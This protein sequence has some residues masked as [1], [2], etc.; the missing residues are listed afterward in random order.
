MCREVK[1]A[2]KEIDEPGGLNRRQISRL[3][4]YAV[5]V[6][7]AVWVYRWVSRWEA[8]KVDCMAWDPACWE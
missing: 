2:E 4:N 3:Q 6:G 5:N 7:A 8:H 1:L